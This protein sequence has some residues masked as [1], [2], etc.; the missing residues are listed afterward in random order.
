MT[1]TVAPVT[2]NR[3]AFGDAGSWP[4]GYD[5]TRLGSIVPQRNRQSSFGYYY[6]VGT[7]LLRFDTSLVPDNEIVRSV[8][9][10]FYVRQRKNANTRYLSIDAHNWD[11]TSGDYVT[12]NTPPNNVLKGVSLWGFTVGQVNE[13][14]LDATNFINKTGPTDIRLHITGGQPTGQNFLDVAPRQ[15]SDGHP[16]AEL[17]I[18]SYVP[19]IYPSSGQVNI[20]GGTARVTSGYIVTPSS[21]QIILGGGTPIAYKIP[22]EAPKPV[23]GP[24]RVGLVLSGRRGAVRMRSRLYLTDINAT[25]IKELP[26]VDSAKIDLSNY[27]TATWKLSPQ[28]H[29]WHGF[30]PLSDFILAT[31]ELK[32]DGEWHEY[33]RGLY[34][35]LG[36]SKTHHITHSEYSSLPG[37]SLEGLLAADGP[38]GAYEVTKGTGILSAVR[39]ILLDRGIPSEKIQFATRADKPLSTNMVFETNGEGQEETWI[40]ICNELLSSGGF[41][42]LWTDELGNFVTCNCGDLE[43]REPNLYYAAMA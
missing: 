11:G 28:M 4:P 7:G 27:R 1:T 6:E 30:D 19:V 26:K 43:N 9:L 8:K 21:G 31:T 42:A 32:M 14:T 24:T 18:E 22:K 12:A 23:Y 36:H 17:V 20:S 29:A 10:R 37:E 2:A 16:A 33:P 39:Q 25:K 15:N 38:N 34:T 5:E 13:I 40:S 41:Y 3:Y 35:F